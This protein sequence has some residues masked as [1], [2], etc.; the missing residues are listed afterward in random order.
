MF[1]SWPALDSGRSDHGQALMSVSTI[2]VAINARLL[3]R[4][5]WLRGAGLSV[6]VH[7]VVPADDTQLREVMEQ[8]VQTIRS[9]S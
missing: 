3:Q 8:V 9:G 1:A 2:V 5:I 7:Y 6:H 4:Q